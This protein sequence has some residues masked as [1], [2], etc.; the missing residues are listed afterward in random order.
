MHE[1]I[2]IFH[3]IRSCTPIALISESPSKSNL[4]PSS[5]SSTP[6]IPNCKM[7]LLT[8]QNGWST[9]QFLQPLASIYHFLLLVHG[10]CNLCS[11]FSATAVC[12]QKGLKFLSGKFFIHICCYAMKH[13]ELISSF[14]QFFSDFVPQR[15]AAEDALKAMAGNNS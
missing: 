6:S 14:M 11:H 1:F 15:V 4:F 3:P 2:H 7:F 10:S 13:E 9:K 12:S 5:L 8:I